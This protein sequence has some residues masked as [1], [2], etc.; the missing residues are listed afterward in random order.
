MIW[1]VSVT[2][3]CLWEPTMCKVALFSLQYLAYISF[4][5]NPTLS[6]YQAKPL[7]KRF[8]IRQ[9][10]N[11]I[12]QKDRD[13]K[14]KIKS[15]LIHDCC[16]TIC[17]CRK[18]SVNFVTVGTQTRYL[19]VHNINV[20]PKFSHRNVREEATPHTGTWCSVQDATKRMLP[21]SH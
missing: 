9:E 19:H 11:R 15:I 12:Q 14:R 20:I 18:W 10:N 17:H 13:D 8:K 5:S 16:S 2:A 1:N 4:G 3:P 7:F 21:I 6:L